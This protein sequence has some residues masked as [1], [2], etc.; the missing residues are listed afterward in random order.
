MTVHFYALGDYVLNVNTRDTIATLRSRVEEVSKVPADQI[1]LT[2][3]GADLTGS[4]R[5]LEEVGLRDRVVVN[6]SRKEAVRACRP[7]PLL[8]GEQWSKFGSES[9][10]YGG[11]CALMRNCDGAD[12][13]ESVVWIEEEETE[14]C[15]ESGR[16]G[17]RRGEGG[18]QALHLQ[19][20]RHSSGRSSE[21][22]S[23]NTR[24]RR[25]EAS[26]TLPFLVRIGGPQHHFAV[27]AA[28]MRYTST[29][30]SLRIARAAALPR[31]RVR[32]A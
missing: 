5:T 1:R 13:V 15:S 30:E 25:E 22:E 2:Y 14:V 8:K 27:F 26:H 12:R 9:T 28:P 16:R 4:P 7:V 29:A 21:W 18:H 24:M 6:A 31:V 19:G 20:Q 10:A 3:W 32:P 23:L 17:R 11:V